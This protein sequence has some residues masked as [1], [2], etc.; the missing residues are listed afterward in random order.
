MKVNIINEKQ[1]FTTKLDNPIKIKELKRVLS[2]SLPKYFTS[3]FRLMD[4]NEILPDSHIIKLSEE[5]MTLYVTQ[6]EPKKQSLDN[7]PIDE[8]IQQATDAK[9]K[10]KTKN[11][12]VSGN[13]LDRVSIL[14][15]MMNS[16]VSS[17]NNSNLANREAQLSEIQNLLRTLMEQPRDIIRQPPAQVVADENLV[18]NL[19]DMGFPE[20]RCR[21]ALVRAR[22]NVNRATDLLLSDELDYVQERYL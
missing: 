12:N 18:N 17:L 11:K 21:L 1:C 8:L 5:E 4:I 3:D 22:N 13:L 2:T 15:Q 7:T 9:A 14:E 10:I 16:T 19:K 6:P 20:D